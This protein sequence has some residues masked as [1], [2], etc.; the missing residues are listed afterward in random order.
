TEVFIGKMFPA[1]RN[2]QYVIHGVNDPV[3]YQMLYNTRQ[4]YRVYYVPDSNANV[5]LISHQ[6]SVKLTY[7][8]FGI[9]RDLNS[10]V[11]INSG[12]TY[13]ISVYKG[14][15]GS[16][17]AT[18]AVPHNIE[19]TEP[20]SDILWSKPELSGSTWLSNISIKT[21][22]L[23][24]PTYFVLYSKLGNFIPWNFYST[25]GNDLTQNIIFQATAYD[26][27]KV[28]SVNCYLEMRGMDNNFALFNQP[29]NFSATD[30]FWK[31]WYLKF[32]ETRITNRS[33][34]NG[35][36]SVVGF[37]GSYNAASKQFIAKALWDSVLNK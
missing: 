9:Y 16:Y 7:T 3:L 21:S 25:N 31:D 20:S 32:E 12:T 4:H 36:N 19:I 37:L 26:T 22:Y 13:S 30:D 23:V 10:E 35:P 11:K 15:N 34:V 8:G 6:D 17:T 28:D 1:D 33:S 2:S 27:T 24:R 14:N 29:Y 5:L 18:T